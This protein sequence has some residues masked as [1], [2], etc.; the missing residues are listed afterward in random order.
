VSDP[1]TPQHLDLLVVGAGPAGRRAAI[2]AARLGARTAV[3]DR[4]SAPT[5]LLPFRA[6]HAAAGDALAARRARPLRAG[7]RPSDLADLLWRADRVVEDQRD[8]ARD[9]LRRERVQ[10]LEGVARFASPHDLE[11][12]GPR[13]TW[14]VTADR[15]V[16][17]TGGVPRDP[18]GAGRDGRVVLAPEDL[19]ALPRLPGRLVVAG[20]G[21]AGLEVAAVAAALGAAVTLVDPS[22]E[23]A[24]E[25]DHDVVAALLYHLRGV[26]VTAHLG[27]RVRTVARPVGGGVAAA[28]DDGGEVAADAL[29]FAGGRD[30]ATAGLGLEAAGLAPGPHGHIP[31]DARGRTAVPHLY[32]AGEVTGAPGRTA[33]ALDAGRRAALAALDRLAP[34]PRSPLP[35]AVATI[36]EIAAAGPTG[37]ALARAG[38]A[39]VAGVARFADLVRGE[40]SGERAGMLKLLADPAT[41][42]VLAVHIVG[43]AAGE[44]V[45]VGQA[46]IAGGMTVHDLADAVTGPATFAEA[47]A[48]AAA[49]AA[50][51]IDLGDH[52]RCEAGAGGPRLGAY[53]AG[54]AGGPPPGRPP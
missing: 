8:A 41:G 4:G 17:A 3:A 16:I 43:A 1:A 6:L 53:A 18:P 52:P 26:G 54:P 21:V 31:V 28:L 10:V 29:V 2:T 51:R 14:R 36:P 32:A 45:H 24:P 47:Y 12:A 39:S 30:G 15:V 48:V 49:D 20:A 11:V 19:P 27:R 23:P 35:L 50:R 40:L 33:A 42:R 34:P 22:P 9:Q 37:R 7:E 13:G 44:L 46:A 5:G 38:T 25:L